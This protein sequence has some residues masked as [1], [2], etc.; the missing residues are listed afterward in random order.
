MGGGKVPALT[1]A[2]ILDFD[3][4]INVNNW[5]SLTN[6]VSGNFIL[7]PLSGRKKG[8]PSFVENAPSEYISCYNIKKSIVMLEI[9]VDWNPD[10]V[11]SQ[12]Y[13]AKADSPVS[14]RKCS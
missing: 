12:K 9:K 4:G 6:P 13:S 3:T 2:Q 7:S 11:Y 10:T 1:S 14:G 5:R 8:A